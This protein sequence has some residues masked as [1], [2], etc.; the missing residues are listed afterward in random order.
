MND[1]VRVILNTRPPR[2][3]VQ[4]DLLTIAGKYLP[5]ISAV[6]MSVTT[7]TKDLQHAVTQYILEYLSS[8][9]KYGYPFRVNKDEAVAEIYQAFCSIITDESDI[10]DVNNYTFPT[11]STIDDVNHMVTNLEKN[12]DMVCASSVPWLLQLPAE[13][14]IQ[15]QAICNLPWTDV[16]LTIRT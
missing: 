13:N 3:G 1:F 8:N 2:I 15:A 14:F 16:C 6:S 9:Y 7:N 4:Q 12:M 11:T 5:N 10:Y